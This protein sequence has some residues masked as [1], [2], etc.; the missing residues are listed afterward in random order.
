MVDS[1]EKKIIKSY[2]RKIEDLINSCEKIYDKVHPNGILQ[3]RNLE[4]IQLI[5]KYKTPSFHLGL[6]KN[7]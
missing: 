5:K 6:T 2:K 7:D 3:E 1:I 4:V